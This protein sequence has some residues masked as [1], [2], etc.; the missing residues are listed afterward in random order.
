MFNIEDFMEC[1][2]FP[3]WVMPPSLQIEP[4]GSAK[5]NCQWA[6]G[7]RLTGLRW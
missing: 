5:Q 4:T 6:V 2:Q 7:Q 3:R 1:E